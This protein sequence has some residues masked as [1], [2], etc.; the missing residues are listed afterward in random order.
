MGNLHP[1]LNVIHSYNRYFILA[2][3]IF[4]L[5]RAYRGWLGK[6]AYDK[7]D[8]AAGAALLGLSHLQLLVGL[9]QYAFTSAYSKAAFQDMGAAM[10]NEWL[11]Y[12]GVEHITMMILAISMIQIGR[13]LSKKA[14]D[15]NAKHKKMAIYVSIAVVLILASL[16]PK[17]LLLSTLAAVTTGS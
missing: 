6:H 10:K 12:F 14:I 7:T 17:G 11:R 2:A 13:S 8:N 4:V 3:I 16:A 15:D 9:I 5:F 1:I